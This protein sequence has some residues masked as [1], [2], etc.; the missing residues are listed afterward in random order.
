[1]LTSIDSPAK[2]HDVAGV[3]L[4]SLARQEVA[5]ES[6][7]CVDRQISFNGCDQLW[8]ADRFGE[9]GMSLDLQARSCLSSCDESCQK[10]NRCSVQCWI[11]FNPRGDFAPIRFRHRNIKKNK[12]GLN[13]LRCLVSPG[14]FVLFPNGVTAGPLQRDFGRV[15]KIAIVIDDQDARFLFG[16]IKG[17]WEKIHFDSSIHNV[18]ISTCVLY[19]ASIPPSTTREVPVVNF[20]SSEQ[21]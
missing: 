20:A 12:V 2:E 6:A 21:R 15:G 19:W 18:S 5:H 9:K 16:L 7:R 11:G 13:A 8:N 10:N 1:M 3:S 14:W 17:R 4:F